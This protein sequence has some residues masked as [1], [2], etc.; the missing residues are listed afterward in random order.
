M[1]SIGLPTSH[2]LYPPFPSNI[3]T[4]PL[5][6]ISLDKLQSGDRD[7][8]KA[9]FEASKNLGFFYLKLGDSDLGRKLVDEAEQLNELQKEFYQLPYAEREEFAR[10]KIDAFFGYREV[11]L[12]GVDEDGKVR[13][14]ETYNVRP[15]FSMFLLVSFI[16]SQYC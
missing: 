5:V 7:E 4:A 11:E 8:S 16:H 1:G 10:E 9:F 2:H 6:S 12:E 15:F 13:R 3:K 14:N